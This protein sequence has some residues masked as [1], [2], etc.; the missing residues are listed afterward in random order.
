MNLNDQLFQGEHI[1]LGPIDHEKDAEIETRWLHNVEYLRM[2]DW[3]LAYPLAPAQ[4]K[5]RYETLE[6]EQ[7]EKNNLFYFTIRLKPEAKLIGFTKLFWI[8]WSHS[9]GFVQMGIGES[10]HHRQGHGNEA[11]NLLLRYAFGELNLY[12]LTAVIPEYNLAALGLFKQAGFVEEVRRRQAV[13]RA[14]RRWDSI[15]LGVL[16]RE[17]YARL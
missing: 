10:Q 17:W 8:E 11:L 6:K 4:L 12:R 13:H 2:L 15:H 9:T 7:Q 1:F 16:S 5:K 3:D 14:G